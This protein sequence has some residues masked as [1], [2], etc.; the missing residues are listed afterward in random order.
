MPPETSPEDQA[1]DGAQIFLDID[2]QVSP[3]NGFTYGLQH[4]LAMFGGMIAVPLVVGAAL[5]LPESQITILVTGT[6]LAS[7]V[8]TLIQ[9][10]GVG[11]VGAKYPIMMGAGFA[12]LSPMINIGGEFGLPTIFGAVFV[13]TFLEGLVGLRISKLEHLFTPVVTGSVVAVIGLTLIPLSFTWIAGDGA[14]VNWGLGAFV[15]ILVLFFNQFFSGYI[16]TVAIVLGIIVGYIVSV[17]L[18]VV[19]FTQVGEASS[20][21]L[22]NF[23]A[24]GLPEF[25]ITAIIVIIFAAFASMM[26]TVGDVFATGAATN[27]EVTDEQ[28]NGGVSADGFS[29]FLSPIFTGFPLTSFSQNIGV[30]AITGVASRFAVAAGGILLIVLGL[31]PKLGALVTVMPEPVLGGS[32]LVMFGGIAAAGIRRVAEQQP[33][34][35]RDIIIVSLTLG[36][37]VGFGT[38]PAAAFS[39]FPEDLVVLLESGIAM[40]AL[41]AIVLSLLLPKEPW[42]DT[43]AF[44]I[45]DSGSDED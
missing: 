15:L 36:A 27:N 12:Y 45:G 41:T 26:E 6:L 34:N 29:S 11:P 43:P 8:G 5:E 31:S 28:L 17:P 38:A 1:S 21:G 24:F 44:G 2:E 37:G 4:V 30:I 22:P 23:F 13:A 39:G 7:G 32:T 35:R 3:W 10:L 40:G 16:S 42:F 14:L 25:H 9:S 19:D 18:G 20:V 33:L